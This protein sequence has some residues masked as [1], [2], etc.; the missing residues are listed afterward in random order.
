MS[1][2]QLSLASIE[3][4]MELELVDGAIAEESLDVALIPPPAVSFEARNLFGEAERIA[5]R[6]ATASTRRQY[7]SI[8]RSF[9]DW[10]AA[11]LGRPPV[12]GDLDADAIAAYRRHLMSRGGRGRMVVR[13]RRRFSA[14]Q[15]PGVRLADQ[16]RGG[17]RERSRIASSRWPRFCIRVLTAPSTWPCKRRRAGGRPS[18]SSAA[19]RS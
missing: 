17:P 12:V 11:E 13:G 14:R 10:L 9:G 16:R 2:A 7:A 4:E 19:R 15:C 8:F 18:N 6:A 1:S 3:P 5:A